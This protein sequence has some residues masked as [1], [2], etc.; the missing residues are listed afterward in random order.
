MRLHGFVEL[1]RLR[2]QH[3]NEVGVREILQHMYRLGS[4]HTACAEALEI[5][6]ELKRFPNEPQAQLKAEAWTKRYSPDSSYPFAWGVFTIRMDSED[7][8]C[9]RGVF[10]WTEL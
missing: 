6:F 8:S 10:L 5:L 1:A 7:S 4:Q 3:G 2:Y 9:G